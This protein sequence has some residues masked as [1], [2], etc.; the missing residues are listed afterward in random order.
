MSSFILY[1]TLFRLVLSYDVGGNHHTAA[2]SFLLGQADE[3]VIESVGVCSAF[4]KRFFVERLELRT[5][6]T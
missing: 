4:K 6:T 3:F 5:A 2:Y 1:S